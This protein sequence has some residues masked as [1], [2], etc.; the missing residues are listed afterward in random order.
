MTMNIR[1][2]EKNDLLGIMELIHQ[3]QRYFKS[4]N[5]DQWQDGYP[6]EEA[7]LNDIQKRSSY[8]LV[9]EDQIVGTM[10]Y[11]IEP[12][13]NYA[14]IDGQWLTNDQPYAVIHR[15]VVDENYKGKSLAKQLF[16]YVIDDC[17]AKDVQS[18]RIDTH[19]DNLSMQRFLKKNG[20]EA[21]GDIRL[22]DS[23]ALRIAFEKLLNQ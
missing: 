14:I 7:I 18:I 4:Q 6:N 20:F 12:D 15:I 22:L 2:S 11:A 5:I 13:K 8:V 21:C 1:K 3:A 9:D 19:H 23:Q 10:Y 16:N 17:Q